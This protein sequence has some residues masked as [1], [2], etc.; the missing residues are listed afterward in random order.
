MK[1][2]IA[3]IF[4]HIR[5]DWRDCDIPALVARMSAT[6]GEID[7]CEHITIDRGQ[8]FLA[9]VESCGAQETTLRLCERKKSFRLPARADAIGSGIFLIVAVERGYR[10]AQLSDLGGSR[11]DLVP[12][13]HISAEDAAGDHW[14]DGIEWEDWVLEIDNKAVTHRPDL[15]GHRGFAR[16]VA[17]L[18]LLPFASE[19]QI[20]SQKPI[21]HYEKKSPIIDLTHA[22]ACT[23]CAGLEIAD[24]RYTPSIPWIVSRLARID[25]RSL[26]ALVDFGNY[27]MFDMGQPMH[28]FDAAAIRGGVLIPRFA[29]PGEKLTLID[30]ATVELTAEETV[31]ADAEGVLSL[32][33]IMGGQESGVRRTTSKIFLEAA[34]FDAAAIRRSALRFK[35]RTESSARFEKSL[36]PN[37][38][39]FA[40]NRYLAL[41]SECGLAGR[42]DESITSVG[43]LAHETQIVFS[44][45]FLTDRIGCTVR[46]GDVCAILGRLGFGV[47]AVDGQAGLSYRVEVPTFRG[48]KDILI[49][50]DLV[51]EVARYYGYNNIVPILPSRQMRPFDIT[52]PM[53]RRQLKHACAYALSMREIDAY[54]F[55]DESWLQELAFVPEHAVMVVNPVSENW[56]RLVTTLIPHLLKAVA[57]NAIHEPE[58]RFF[59]L[60]LRWRDR[61]VA[62]VL[63]QGVCAG[64][65]YRKSSLDFFE[66]KAELVKLFDALGLIVDWARPTGER[67]P[68]AAESE[69]AELSV[70]EQAIG[71]VARVD[72]P[73]ASRAAAGA[74]F[75]FEFETE[76]I[77]GRKAVINRY[78]SISRYQETVLDVSMLVG[79]QV[80][81]AELE[82]AVALAD[83]RVRD[84]RLLDTF[85]K[86]EWG[87]RRSVTLRYVLQDMEKTLVREEIDEVQQAV[88]AAV[89]ALGAEVR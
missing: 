56:R 21:R 9:E 77:L 88:H 66:V 14:R 19:E 30:G 71:Y 18:L 53:R 4:D 40:I 7:S 82:A 70:G 41:V 26:N 3:W 55:F 78:E 59:E 86:S 65:F 42:A 33:G 22:S 52:R 31:I 35:V 16:E 5:A 64:V 15:W 72:T 89:I 34:H 8:F 60:A 85:E 63:E 45:K 69:C 2:S 24:V 51:E 10:W 12:A 13:L 38:N 50:E 49:P 29:H 37:Q 75:A 1:I 79:Y 28:V 76:P 62:G 68:W 80:T 6:I 87:D 67:P 32:A 81:V 20:A 27:V 83:A 36:D 47:Q 39:T 43:L 44:H 25:M 73:L 61:G 23:R 17:A 84:V 48:T 54:S 74:L 46:E 11:K 57:L 58:L